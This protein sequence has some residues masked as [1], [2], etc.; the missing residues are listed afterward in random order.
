MQPVENLEIKNT[1]N[2][3]E[4]TKHVTLKAFLNDD[5]IMGRHLILYCNRG[6]EEKAVGVD[7][8]PSI[9]KNILSQFDLDGKPK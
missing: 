7:I 4:I 1:D 2:L 9:S 6:G 8:H 5:D 3:I